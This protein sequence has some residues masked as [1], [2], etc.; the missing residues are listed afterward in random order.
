MPN[1]SLKRSAN[2]RTSSPACGALPAPQP[3]ARLATRPGPPITLSRVPQW[4]R[5]RRVPPPASES[6]AGSAHLLSFPL[7]SCIRIGSVSGCV[8]LSDRLALDALPVQ[9]PP[10]HEPARAGFVDHMQAM[11]AADQLVQRLVSMARLLANSQRPDRQPVRCIGLARHAPGAQPTVLQGTGRP[12]S[13]SHL[14]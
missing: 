13:R 14:V 5:L 1:P 6:V 3:W 8:R 2:G 11:P 4:P 12:G 10:D 9:L 7:V